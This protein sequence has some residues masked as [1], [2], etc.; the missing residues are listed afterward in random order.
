[1][2]LFK[3]DAIITISIIISFV[4]WLDRL[5]DWRVQ[6]PEEASE[7]KMR[8]LEMLAVG[9]GMAALE[10]DFPVAEVRP[11]RYLSLPASAV[12]ILRVAG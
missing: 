7:M 5:D 6:L 1:M 9:R 11:K 4:S 10:T 12:P 8:P 2:K 3:V